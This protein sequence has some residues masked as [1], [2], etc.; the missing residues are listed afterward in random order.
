MEQC[1]RLIK[2][3]ARASNQKLRIPLPNIPYD[4]DFSATHAIRLIDGLIVRE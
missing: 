3:P 4:S 2:V 1:L